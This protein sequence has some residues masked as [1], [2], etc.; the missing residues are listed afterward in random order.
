MDSETPIEQTQDERFRDSLDLLDRA[1]A[2]VKAHGENLKDMPSILFFGS[3]TKLTIGF[4][5]MNQDSKQMA[6]I[7]SLFEGQT[8]TRRATSSTDDYRL[9]DTVSGLSFVWY[10]WKSQALRLQPEEV[11]L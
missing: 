5:Y 8:A 11:T 4:G 10:V 9:D 1:V 7:R 3:S 6:A 2:W